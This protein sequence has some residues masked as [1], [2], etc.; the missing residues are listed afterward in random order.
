M[1][2]E[3]CAVCNSILLEELYTIKEYPISI[4]SSVLP[5][6]D[7]KY[8]DLVFNTCNKCGC[9]QLKHLI[10]IKILYQINHN[11]TY[12]TPTWKKHHQDF[13]TFVLNSITGNKIV[14]VGGSSGTLAKKIIESKPDIA[15]TLIDLCDL[16][17]D[18]SGIT[19]V[20]ANCEDY[21][22][23]SDSTVV[24]SHIFEHLYKP[25]DFVKRLKNNN[26][27]SVIISVPD[28]NTWLNNKYLSF[29]HVEHTYYCDKETILHIFSRC[30]YVCKEI[31]Y[32]HKHSIFMRFI[33]SD[34]DS[35]SE[36]VD[37]IIDSSKIKKYFD[38]R[39]SV[40]KNIVLT[41]MTFIVP[42]GHFGQ[43]IY[44]FLK[45]KE[46]IIGFLD[47][48]T[49]KCGKRVYGTTH[50]TYP[51]ADIIKYVDTRVDILIHA[52]PYTDEIKKQLLTYHTN[53][54]FIDIVL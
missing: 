42:A 15:Y 45:D 49:T 19:F 35:E 16:V 12:D 38:I 28:M 41:Q 39:E 8:Q 4:S 46:K 7:D 51:M 52:G 18:I 40:L 30:G 53:L 48:D 13:S 24:M 22:Y 27:S 14:E 11:N 33:L 29:L 9:V 43:L 17:I 26:V 25:Y 47:N 6:N 36:L 23:K 34:N 5:F 44:Y 37:T 54:R 20:Q 1:N 3:N 32:F 21:I 31:K 2:R 50:I 10:D